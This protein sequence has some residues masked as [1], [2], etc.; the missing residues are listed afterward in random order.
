MTSPQGPDIST[1]NEALEF[2]VR[3]IG[4]SRGVQLSRNAQMVILT[5]LETGYEELVRQDQTEVYRERVQMLVEKIIR[6]LPEKNYDV[7]YRSPG[8]LV[9]SFLP[10]SA[11]SDALKSICPLWPFC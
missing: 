9:P 8:A 3:A 4:R 11:L 1:P 10:P 2:A 7:E 5:R 6:Q